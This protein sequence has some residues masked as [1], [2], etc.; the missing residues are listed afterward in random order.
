MLVSFNS[1][2][3]SATSGAGTADSSKPPELIHV[4]VGFVLLNL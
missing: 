2:M 4:L 3:T 1:N